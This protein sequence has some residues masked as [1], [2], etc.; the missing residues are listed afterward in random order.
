V[1]GELV[2][3]FDPGVK[4]RHQRDTVRT[5]GATIEQHIDSIDGAVV[6]VDPSESRDVAQRLEQL[7]SVRFVEPNYI[8]RAARI[9][10]DPAFARQW[11]LR[12]IGAPAAW[13]VVTGTPV[14]VAV[15]DTGVAYSHP[16]LASNIWVNPSEQPNGA[17][18]DADGFV[19]DLHGADLF[20]YDADPRDDDGHGT[21]V[22]GIIGAHGN[23]A[24]GVAGVNWSVRI[25]ALKFLDDVGDGSTADAA[26]AIDYAVDHGA[27]VINASWSGAEFSDALYSAIQRAGEKGVV[28]VASAG[29]EGTNSDREPEYPAAFDLPNIVSV[30]ATDEDDRLT[31]FSSYGRRSV[32]VAA[33]GA[34]IY[35][36]VPF[37]QRASGYDELS[38][39]SMAAPFVSGAAA[40]YLSRRPAASAGAVRDAILHGAHRLPS[41]AR[42]TVSGGRLDVAAMLRYRPASSRPDSD[43]TAPAPFA[44]RRAG[45][46]RVSRAGSLLFRW[47]RSR[48]AGGIREYQ[49]FVDGTR[50]RTVRDPDGPGG[51][52]PRPRTKVRLRGGR[53]RWFVRA[54]DYAGNLRDSHSFRGRKLVRH[55]VV[56]VRATATHRRAG[57]VVSGAARASRRVLVGTSG[58]DTIRGSAA[59][60]K[61]YGGRSAD[62]LFGYDGNDLIRAGTGRDALA[63]GGGNDLLYGDEAADLMYG[64]DGADQLHGATAPDA[65]SG[66]AGDDQLFGE[67]GDDRMSGG[68]GNDALD[69]GFGRDKMSGDAGDDTINAGQAGDELHGGPGNDRLD[70]GSAEDTLYGDEGDDY[71]QGGSAR[72]QIYAGPGDDTVNAVEPVGALS[73]GVIDCGPGTD[74]V[75]VDRRDLR[76]TRFSGCETIVADTTPPPIDP[77]RGLQRIGDGRSDDLLGSDRNDILL[78]GAGDDVL[79]GF[80]G[81]DVIWG[82]HVPH[83]SGNDRIYGGPG[84]DQIFGNDGADRIFGEEG[85]DRISGGPGPDRIDGGPGDDELRPDAG[86]DH[87]VAGTGN[88]VVR[89]FGGGKHDRVDCGPGRDTAYVD[90]G[91][92]TR[93]C[94]RV[95]HS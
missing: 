6:T 83:T 31:D 28:F 77:A 2:V 58:K 93:G 41:L 75:H 4:G 88:D 14:T 64:Q 65:M 44:L 46:R 56:F 60:N 27:R 12:K 53:H 74:T 72:D 68:D 71:L 67:S 19:D 32:D 62:R 22:A 55:S 45:S 48:D 18:D 30:A 3:G 43:T 85:N 76:A 17:D 59:D 36:T 81:A 23:N 16:D 80:G 33:P 66:G 35:S 13:N 50:V 52:E 39:T 47:R 82:D 94:E 11:G 37:E 15:L 20:N 5:A 42:K 25:M 86:A 21:H 9:P 95:L 73:E 54:V 7:P 51:R 90:K 34:N 63:G 29:N 92:R 91:D 69:G 79:R 40:L 57:L 38:G 10:K 1:P 8:V 84:D 61:I 24:I 87:V 89:A 26:R 78:G 70:G 49:L